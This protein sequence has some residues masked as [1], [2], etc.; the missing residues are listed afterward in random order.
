[1][2]TNSRSLYIRLNFIAQFFLTLGLVLAFN[3]YSHVAE[4]QPNGEK[5]FN[6]KCAR[7]HKIFSDFTGPALKGVN[8]RRPKKWLKKWIKNSSAVIASGD[9]YGKKIYNEWDQTDMPAFPGLSDKDIEA[10]LD[11]IK[12]RTKQGP[13]TASAQG[14][15]GK[16]GQAGG[17]ASTS[18]IKTILIVAAIS[19]FII[20]IILSRIL[21]SLNRVVREKT[22]ESVPEPLSLAGIVKSKKFGVVVTLVVFIFLGSAV[23]EGAASLGRQQDYAPEQ[24]IAF[25]HKIHAGKNNIDC[26]Y[27]HFGA[28]K[29][30]NAGIPPM[31]VCMNC[32]EAVQK[33]PKKVYNGNTGT[34][35]IQKLLNHWENKEPIKWTKVHN[36]PDFVYFN[37]SQHVKVAGI[38]CQQCHGKVQEMD[39]VQQKKSLSMGWCIDCHRTTE[40]NFDNKYYDMLENLHKKLKSG[41]IEKVNAADIGAT[42]CQRCHY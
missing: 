22:G 26:K 37:H 23:Y 41:E 5:I 17:Q 4:A 34:E 10:V 18:T 42:D 39:V 12:K 40:V 14:G 35:E 6:Q 20:A 9:K 33:Y 29:S 27:C 7:C 1:M 38:E 30:K 28:E 21:S 25:S 32:H 19:L 11:Y 15:S 16:G 24:P 2:A 31:N 3:F 8:D 36:L 13:K